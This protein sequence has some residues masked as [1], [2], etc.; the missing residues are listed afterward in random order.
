MRSL[1]IDITELASWQGKVTGV[2]RVMDEICRRYKEIDGVQFVTWLPTGYVPF[3]YPQYP[4]EE[5]ES[6]EK[7]NLAYR[8]ARR[9]HS[10][11]AVV[12]KSV[13]AIKKLQPLVSS[14]SAN[15]H[16]IAPGKGDVLFVLADWH[17]GDPSFVKYLQDAHANG[18]KIVQ[19][20]YDLLPIVTPQY[21]GH[22]TDML[23]NYSRQVY[24]ICDLMFSISE[25]TKQDTIEW[26]KDND[27]KVPPID[28]IRLGD[29]FS[30]AEPQK[31]TNKNLPE[32]YILC[33]GTIE[34]RKNH[35]LLYYTY[36]QSVRKGIDLPPT[37]IVGRVGW[38]ANDIYKIMQLDP[39]IKNKFIFMHQVDDNELSWLYENCLF[40]IYPSFYEGWGLPIAE[41]IAYG[42]AVAASNTSSMT[43][44]AGDLIK[45][46]SPSS[47]D[48]CLDRI[49]ELVDERSREIATVQLGKYKPY[50]WDET[51][52]TIDKSIKGL[53]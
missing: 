33:V 36:K 13:S 42:K 12:R 10:R 31:P 25:H 1:Y 19:M 14:N 2:P 8:A 51:F 49:M 45:Y 38:L 53:V 9:V 6:Q 18:I 41:S 39:D 22:S 16:H 37:V 17:G 48:E 40:S 29:D 52:A 20:V 24:P 46:F 30:K 34:A 28:V 32:S 35:A 23:K 26:L 27:L 21:S 4:R 50:S 43:E 5:H 47:P 15:K 11:L 44:I 3:V 7:E